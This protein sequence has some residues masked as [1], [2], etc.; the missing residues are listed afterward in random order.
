MS[1]WVKCLMNLMKELQ[2]IMQKPILEIWQLLLSSLRLRSRRRLLQNLI[3]FIRSI[4]SKG[5]RTS[6]FTLR[7][8]ILVL[9]TILKS[10]T[11]NGTSMIQLKRERSLASLLGAFKS[12]A[13]YTMGVSCWQNLCFLKK[14]CITQMES[15]ISG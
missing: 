7:L 10:M 5:K 15:L 3:K 1:D 13:F 9:I 6:I 2:L 14:S 4:N 11:L 12:N 8:P